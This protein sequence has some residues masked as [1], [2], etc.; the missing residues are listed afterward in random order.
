MYMVKQ[1][2]FQITGSVNMYNSI[3]SSLL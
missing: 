3:S 1:N 2:W